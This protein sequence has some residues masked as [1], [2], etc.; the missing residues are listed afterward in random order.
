MK[1]LIIYKLKFAGIIIISVLLD[2]ALHLATSVYSTMPETPNYSRMAEL[3]GTE[4][5]AVLWALLAFSGAAYVF[6]RFR[7]SIP[8]SGFAKG[9][10]YGSAIALLWLFAMLEGVPLFGHSVINEFVVG[11]SDA[12]PVLLMSILSGLL[13]VKNTVNTEPELPSFRQKLLSICVFSAIF[14]FGRYIAYFTGIIQSGIKTRPFYTFLW[15]LLMGA[16]IGII[17]IL[18]GQVGKKLSLRRRAA[19]FGFCVFGVNW[20]VFL[21]FMPILFAG[22]FTDVL[23]RIVIDILLVTIGYYLIL[24]L[25]VARSSGSKA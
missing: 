8:G 6:Y 19:V 2:I 10:R 20:A 15:T 1:T 5:S 9:L 24:T 22:Y 18:L 16:C 23:S 13:I 17:C 4:I 21:V 14:T 25:G 3:L 11:L 12:V 7:N